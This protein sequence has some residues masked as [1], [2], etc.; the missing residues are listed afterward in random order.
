MLS[1]CLEIRP[2]LSN[3][4]KISVCRFPGI[5]EAGSLSQGHGDINDLLGFAESLFAERVGSF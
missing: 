2:W 1:V 5:C 3:D 4:M